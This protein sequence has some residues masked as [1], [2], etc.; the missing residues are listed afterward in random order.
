MTRICPS[1]CR[2]PTCS[3]ETVADG[4][5][6]QGF[7]RRSRPWLRHWDEHR[8][9]QPSMAQPPSKS[10]SLISNLSQKIYSYK[11]QISL[12]KELPLRLEPGQEGA[13]SNNNSTSR[14]RWCSQ[15]LLVKDRRGT[16]IRSWVSSSASWTIPHPTMSTILPSKLSLPNWVGP[17]YHKRTKTRAPR[18]WRS[19]SPSPHS[20]T[21]ETPRS[22][23]KGSIPQTLI[24]MLRDSSCKISLMKLTRKGPITSSLWLTKPIKI[25]ERLK[26][27]NILRASWKLEMRSFHL[28]CNTCT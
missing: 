7:W 6:L 23:L 9:M 22:L 4:R 8:L 24:Q 14:G 1:L 17:I 2:G 5:A 19:Q 11:L 15:Q 18:R 25:L 26:V 20:S 21:L 10:S 12:S 13:Y 3:R 27:T 16:K 28:T